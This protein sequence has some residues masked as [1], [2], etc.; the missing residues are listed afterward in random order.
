M[1]RLK[2]WTKLSAEQLWQNW[3]TDFASDDDAI[4]HAVWCANRL[5]KDKGNKYTR[6]RFYSIKEEFVR[7]YADEGLAVRQEVLYCYACDGFD[8]SEEIEPCLQ[9]GGSGI[10]KSRWLY[11]YSFEVA[12][13]VYSFHSYAEPIKL[14]RGEGVDVGEF[15]GKFTEDEISSMRLPWS[16]LLKMLGYVAAAM[17]KMTF[18][19]DYGGYVSGWPADEALSPDE[20]Q[21]REM[22]KINAELSQGISHQR[23]M[24]LRRIYGVRS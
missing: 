19:Y 21:R 20:A 23:A 3:R 13:Q 15:G 6:R 5:V 12:G 9:C 8:T 18:D 14:G 22:A 4:A 10:Y 17:W 24:E 2:N 11:V 1:S 16:G 7:R